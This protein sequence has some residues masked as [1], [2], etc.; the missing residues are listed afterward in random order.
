ME[1]KMSDLDSQVKNKVITIFT[2]THFLKDIYFWAN[3]YTHKQ[4]NV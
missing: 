1:A 3:N 4:N 2:K